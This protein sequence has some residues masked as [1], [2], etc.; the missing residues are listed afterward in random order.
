MAWTI[1]I[2]L[3]ALALYLVGGIIADKVMGSKKSEKK[4]LV[5]KAIEVIA[6]VF[7]V[8]TVTPMYLTNV[9][10]GILKN[11]AEAMQ[12]QEQEK[13]S[14]GIKSY[15][16]KN[17]DSMTRNAPILGKENAEKTIY[18]FSAHSCG[19]CRRAHAEL[20]R[21]VSER[22]DVRVVMK[23]FSIHGPLS[24]SAARA[25]IAA[26]MQSN[27]KAIALDK[28]LMAK[29]YYTQEDL[30]D[31]QKAPEIVKNNVLELA[32]SVGLDVDQLEK[33]MQSPTVNAEMAQVR[34]LAQRF[35]IQGTP[36][37][38][39]GDEAFPGAIPYQQIVDA[40]K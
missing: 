19:Y 20:E 26:K 37:L 5:K 14:K 17:A 15:V 6:I 4:N 1:L 18:L 34:D 2:L 30:K 7:V 23:N 39:I 11:M 9:N 32:E 3:V 31:Q 24:D 25:T 38:I 28:A 36:F 35:N 12:K 13:A 8:G 21:V 10:P 29:E 27:D 33:D 16:R 22:D 40:L